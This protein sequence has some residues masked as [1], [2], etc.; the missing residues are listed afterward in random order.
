MPCH[1]WILRWKAKKKENYNIFFRLSNLRTK[2]SLERNTGEEYCWKICLKLIKGTRKYN[3]FA[4][5]IFDSQ[6]HA[7]FSEA[8]I[9]FNEH[10]NRVDSPIIS[11]KN[12]SKCLSLSSFW[13]K[14][15]HEMIVLSFDTLTLL[16]LLVQED[17]SRFSLSAFLSSQS[18]VVW[19]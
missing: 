1:H 18:S 10:F 8:F 3:R 2:E 11:T 9:D 16:S 7:H 5:W 15:S 14:H 12:T 13:I 4:H 6:R 19:S 17:W